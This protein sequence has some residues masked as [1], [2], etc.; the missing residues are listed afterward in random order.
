LIARAL[1][2]RG[3]TV[4]HILADGSLETYGDAMARLLALLGLPRTDLFRSKQEL[5]AQ[6]VALQEERVAYVDEGL[7]A[8]AKGDAR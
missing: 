4:S 7:A 5:I 2:E 1:V 8:V 6:A 3:V